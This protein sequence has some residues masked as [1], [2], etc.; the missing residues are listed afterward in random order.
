VRRASRS[1]ASAIVAEAK[2][3]NGSTIR[4]PRL[5]Y[6]IVHVAVRNYLPGSPWERFVADNPVHIL[7]C[8]RTFG[9]RRSR[10]MR[11]GP[12]WG[13]QMHIEEALGGVRSVQL[14]RERQSIAA[15][16]LA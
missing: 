4:A 7:R 8:A 2:W 13:A 1:A 9:S 3:N 15:V 14:L 12:N 5:A 11:D 16:M 10:A 6:V